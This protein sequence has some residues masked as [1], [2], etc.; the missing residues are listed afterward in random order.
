MK[1]STLKKYRGPVCLAKPGTPDATIFALWKLQTGPLVQW[2][3]VWHPFTSEAYFPN[4]VC[5]YR[6]FETIRISSSSGRI[7][8][9]L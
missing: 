6:F 5:A 2:R 4:I 9:N 1:R 8:T 7:K 3:D